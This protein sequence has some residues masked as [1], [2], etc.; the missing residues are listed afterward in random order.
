MH[1]DALLARLSAL[2][3]DFNAGKRDGAAQSVPA[4]RVSAGR[5][6]PQPCSLLIFAPNAR[7][8]A[9]MPEVNYLISISWMFIQVREEG[10]CEGMGG[11]GVGGD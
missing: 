6:A 3:G 5:D 4:A 7:L 2:Q 11:G 1:I 8:C 9:E 10:A